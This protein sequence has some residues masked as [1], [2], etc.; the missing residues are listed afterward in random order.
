MRQVRM[1]INSA[2]A[3]VGA[4]IALAA[5]PA[6]SYANSSLEDLGKSG[7]SDW[8]TL[9]L[10][11]LLFAAIAVLVIVLGIRV[12]IHIASRHRDPDETQSR[13]WDFS[14]RRHD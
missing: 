14:W 5:L 6:V 1:L 9:A 13:A 2:L 12:L 7:W 10:V 11:F 4:A 8:N 3:T